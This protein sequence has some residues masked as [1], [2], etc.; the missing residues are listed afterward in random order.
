MNS[1]QRFLL[2]AASA[3]MV[4]GCSIVSPIP[5]WELAKT[6]A[7]IATTVVQTSSGEAVNTVVHAHTKFDAVCIEYNPNT[8][9][10]DIIPALQIALRSNSIDSRVYEAPAA[11]VKCPVWLRYTALIEW[12]TPPLSGRV[13][14]YLTSASLRLEGSEGLVYGST[15]YSVDT[16]FGVSKWA[17]V[18]DK[19]SPLVAALVQGVSTGKGDS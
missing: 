14:P 4:S 17:S 1:F 9:S 13:E 18:H 5:L 2:M 19:L 11:G 7:G 15:Y 3:G 8:P 6:S 16:S 10:V 12:G